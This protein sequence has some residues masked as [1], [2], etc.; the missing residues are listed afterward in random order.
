MKVKFLPQNISV[1]VEPGK[2][3][4]ELARENKLPV[5]SSCNGMCACAECR[6]YIVEGEAH[7]LPPSFME[8]ELIGG[9]YFIDNRRLSCQL[10][11]FGDVTVDLSE[12]VERQK[13]EGTVKKQFLKRLSK[14]STE[15]S[16][17]V[18]GIMVEQDKE[19]NAV[20]VSESEEADSFSSS[21]DDFYKKNGGQTHIAG[22]GWRK[23]GNN[24]RREEDTTRNFQSRDGSGSRSYKK[25]KKMGT[26]RN[27]KFNYGRKRR[28]N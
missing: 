9:G 13:Q 22:K 2:S 23:K 26:D 1:D 25:K 7:I 10:F 19:M 16:S 17:S 4:M 12:Q 21:A 14:G 8:V 24:D 20:H 6:V 18:G 28:K 27:K 11:C 3:V 15:E 5:S